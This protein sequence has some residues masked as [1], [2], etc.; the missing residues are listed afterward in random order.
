MV[1]T[2]LGIVIEVRSEQRLKTSFPMVVT[3]L[4]IVIEVRPVR[5]EKAPFSMLVTELGMIVEELPAIRALSLFRINALQF[6][7]ES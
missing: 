7:R 1:V 2:E 4:G 6:S 5:A 3:E